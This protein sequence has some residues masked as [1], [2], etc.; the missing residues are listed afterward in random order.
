MKVAEV[1]VRYDGSALANH[2]MDVA[3]LAP[4]LLGLSELCKIAN[5]R[6]NG[7]ASSLK[8]LIGADQEQKCFQFSIEVVQ[9]LWQQAQGLLEHKEIKTAKE[10]LE[11]LGLIV[12][13]ASAIFGLFKLW[14]KLAGRPIT[15]ERMTVQDGR[16]VVQLSIVGDNNTVVTYR[17]TYELFKDEAVRE[18]AKR[19]IAP[20]VKPGYEELEFEA[21]GVVQ[22]RVSKVEAQSLLDT[23]AE[24]LPDMPIGEPQT[25]TAYVNV[26]APVY[27]EKATRWRFTYNG[28]H[29]YMDISDTT[30]AIDAVQRGGAMANDLYKVK[31]QIQ[32][33]RTAD[34]QLSAR[35]KIKEVLEF[36]PAKLPFQY[37]L[38]DV[39]PITSRKGSEDSGET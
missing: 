13:P 1:T 9:T 2:R 6:F 38:P 27:D 29:S 39:G 34:G 5:L 22:D 17:E 28:G 24:R 11:W 21:D 19:V 31:L 12:A 8:V 30:I 23:P 25:I 26:Y 20:V 16:N 7:E 37:P 3:D 10:I 18:N 33:I 35:Y 36:S 15:E 14:K 4:A 32:Q